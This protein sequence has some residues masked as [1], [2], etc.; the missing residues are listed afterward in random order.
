MSQRFH[1]SKSADE[2]M[3]ISEPKAKPHTFYLDLVFCTVRY[4]DLSVQGDTSLRKS[5]SV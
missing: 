4:T 2:L 3:T 5:Q 1:L